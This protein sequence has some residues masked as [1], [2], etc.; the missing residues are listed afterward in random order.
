MDFSENQGAILLGAW[1]DVL[2]DERNSDDESMDELEAL[3]KAAGGFC[4]ARAFQNRKS[5]DPATFFGE[6][7]LEEV[8]ETGKNLGAKL[9]VVDNDLSPSQHRAIEDRTE[10]RVIERTGLILDIF[11]QRAKTD[12]GKL[13]VSLAQYRYILPRLTGL[14]IEMSRLGGGIGTRGPGETQLETDRRHIRRRIEQ[15]EG[16][17]KELNR[18]RAQQR[19]LRE[20][21]E[22]PMAALVGYTN[23]G[24][25]T[26]LN[27]LTGESISANDR[28]F[29][30]LDNTTRR[31]LVSPGNEILLTDTVG[32]IR[33]LPHHLIEA[34][35][36]TLDEL[37]FA[38][39]I[40]KV[41]DLSSPQL[42]MQSETVESL[43][44]D[45]C[46]PDVPV[47]EVYNKLDRV[48]ADILPGGERTV[49]ISA[50]TGEGLDKLLEMIRIELE[51]G[52]NRIKILLPFNESGLLDR[53]HSE[54][55][56]EKI[57]YVEGGAEITLV[58]GARLYGLLKRF[59]EEGQ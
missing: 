1:C 44:S 21:N 26:I 54:A 48:T 3:L 22:M 34:F 39:I 8:K 11:A 40:L 29:D 4:L 32:F 27:A 45:L 2:S 59:E 52:K 7:K 9:V 28:L 10:L 5:P 50:K 33:R 25:S 58:C 49:C 31:L 24:K 42:D 37:K 30:T 41:S 19:R 13:Q 47:I 35:A 12:E 51:R 6:G 43:I 36:A 17:L 55:A 20:K 46:P 23:S 38:D 16:E 18:V 57:E 15:L 56:V 53:I 14:G